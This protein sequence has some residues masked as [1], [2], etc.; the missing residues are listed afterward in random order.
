M[1]SAFK[2]PFKCENK[3]SQGWEG[4]CWAQLQQLKKKLELQERC[5][6][7]LRQQ[8]LLDVEN[9]IEAAA[10]KACILE[11]GISYASNSAEHEKCPE[12]TII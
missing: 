7:L 2:F 5:D 8:K 12:R 11:T 4:S 1:Q 6:A 10:L 9:D 3:G